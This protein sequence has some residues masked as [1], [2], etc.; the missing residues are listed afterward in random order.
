MPRGER[1]WRWVPLVA[2]A[3][4]AALC[5]SLGVWQLGRAHEKEALRQRYETLGRDSPVQVSSAA[6]PA[7]DVELRRVVARGTFDPRYTVLID[8][9]VL[10]GVPGYD[11]VTPLCPSSAR[12]VLVN[13]GWVAGLPDRSRL[14]Q[15]RTPEG[16]VEVAGTAVV[17]SKRFLEL[18]SQ[19]VEGKVWENLTIERYRD[20]Y[21]LPIQPFLIRQDSALADGLVREWPPLD[22]GIEKHYGYAFQWFALAATA[23]VFYG[24]VHVRRRR[25]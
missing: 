5:A 4:V 3:V 23:I 16:I 20:A 9:R 11:V 14:P 18:S 2:V 12:C 1:R 17:P 7:K 21:A 13:R 8:N 6:V 22:Y 19:V 24:I 10:H 25:A 15:V